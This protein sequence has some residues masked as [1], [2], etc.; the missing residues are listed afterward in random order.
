[1]ISLSE[2]KKL[3]LLF[4]G[5]E[6][7]PHFD[8]ISFKV[9]KK[10]FATLNKKENRACLRFTAIDQSAFCAFDLTVIYPVPNAWGKYGW[11]L[12]N[13]KKV[14]KATFKDAITT[15]YCTVAPPQL[16][17]KYKLNNLED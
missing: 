2:V 12:I 1:M 13:L 11:T 8:I 7:H 6:E 16:A 15:A 17:K 9:K 5:V 10:I 4:E 3:A 14:K